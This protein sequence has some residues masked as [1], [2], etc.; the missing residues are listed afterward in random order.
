MVDDVHC[1][2]WMRMSCKIKGTHHFLASEGIWGNAK[3]LRSMHQFP[4]A[5][6]SFKETTI[7]YSVMHGPLCC[8][9]SRSHRMKLEFAQR[10]NREQSCLH[11]EIQ[12]YDDMERFIN[13]D[14]V[15]KR[16]KYLL[17]VSCEICLKRWFQ[18]HFRRDFCILAHFKHSGGTVALW[19][20]C[21]RFAVPVATVS[22]V[23][24]FDGLA[25]ANLKSTVLVEAEGSQGVASLC[26]LHCFWSSPEVWSTA[27]CII[28]R[29]SGHDLGI[30]LI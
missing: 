9:L 27:H 2:L 29:R 3:G 26:W 6:H 11:S 18:D 10:L 20:R 5:T 21:F 23:T 8:I 13:S 4:H 28:A 17:Q 15:I 7:K 12:R 22:K 19:P 30:G 14:S 24:F 16:C 25:T 1:I